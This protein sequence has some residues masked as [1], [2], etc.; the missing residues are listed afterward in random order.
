MSNQ[1]TDLQLVTFELGVERYGV[2]IMQVKSIEETKEVRPIPNSPPYV[3]GI[4]NLRGEIIPVINLH[5]RF[6]IKRADLG[7]QDELLSGFLIIRLTGMHIAIIIDRVSRVLSV[8]SAEI[9]PPPQMLTGIG[10]EYI[11]GV[12]NRDDGYLIILDID[13]LFNMREIAQLEQ[14]TGR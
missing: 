4:F 12:V 14:M 8:S 1:A 6:H 2:D 7:D 3:E 9:Q 13:R 11:E 10:A 5:R